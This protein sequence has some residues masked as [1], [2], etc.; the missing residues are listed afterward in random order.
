MKRALSKAFTK[1]VPN[2]MTSRKNSNQM[3]HHSSWYCWA[4]ENE[5]DQLTVELSA[6]VIVPDASPPWDLQNWVLAASPPRA[7]ILQMAKAVAL[8]V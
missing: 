8:W 4:Q 2:M 7:I 5:A 6:L 3:D 1:Q